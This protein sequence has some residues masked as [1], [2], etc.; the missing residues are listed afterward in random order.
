MLQHEQSH[1]LSWFMRV[2]FYLALKFYEQYINCTNFVT[3]ENFDMIT[4][5]F[6]SN[7][8][9]EIILGTRNFQYFSQLDFL[10]MAINNA[11]Q[12]Y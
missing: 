4:I 5:P 9:V 10:C 11:F 6:K 1:F 2:I 7:M 12:D 8:I 3:T